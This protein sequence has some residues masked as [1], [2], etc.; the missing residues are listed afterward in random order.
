MIMS[1]KRKNR[2]GPRKLGE[3]LGPSRTQGI[4]DGADSFLFITALNTTLQTQ[5]RK[6]RHTVVSSG[7]AALTH[8]LNLQALSNKEEGFL[9][10]K[11]TIPHKIIITH[12]I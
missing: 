12:Q 6:R 3:F 11:V 9:L 1:A 2:E 7:I 10:L 5:E 4:K 8:R